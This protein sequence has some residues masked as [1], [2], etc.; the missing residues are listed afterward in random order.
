ME[1]F[2]EFID[3]FSSKRSSNTWKHRP[4]KSWDILKFERFSSFMGFKKLK[5]CTRQK[6]WRW[7]CLQFLK[8][9]KLKLIPSQSWGTPKAESFSNWDLH[10]L[11]QFKGLKIHP[12]WMLR[13]RTQEFFPIL[14]FLP[15]KRWGSQEFDS[16]CPWNTVCFCN[17]I[18]FPPN[19]LEQT[20][21]LIHATNG[22][23]L[24]RH[25]QILQLVQFN[26]LSSDTSQQVTDFKN[27]MYLQAQ[28]FE[29]IWFLYFIDIYI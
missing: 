11:K 23:T 26:T 5:P 22:D 1:T 2:Q 7:N 28:K 16:L 18:F 9:T 20:W 24:D 27:W 12:Y 6:L 14:F 17:L 13:R 21:A 19:V 8:L 3:K 4:A 10:K 15:A 25:R 29:S